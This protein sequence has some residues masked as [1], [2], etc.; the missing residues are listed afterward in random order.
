YVLSETGPAGYAAG[1][2]S[3]AGGAL[4]GATGT[5]ALGGHAT[6]TIT[7]DDQPA[8]LTLVKRGVDGNGGAAAGAEGRERGGEGRGGWRGGGVGGWSGGVGECGLLC[9]VGDGPGGVCGGGVVVCG[10]VVAGRDGDGG[11]GGARDVHDHQ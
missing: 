9:P 2:W 7:N 10:R 5:V 8:R 3:C 4:Q 1:A 6:C 11:A